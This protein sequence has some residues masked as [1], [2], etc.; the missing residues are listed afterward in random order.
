VLNEAGIPLSTAQVWKIGRVFGVIMVFC[1]LK[2]NKKNGMESF[3]KYFAPG[4]GQ[5]IG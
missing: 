1:K 3:T 2:Y 5:I 4:M